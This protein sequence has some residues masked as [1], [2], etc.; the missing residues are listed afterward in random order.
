[1]FK[2]VILTLII[3]LPLMA[4]AFGTMMVLEF[5][6]H[7]SSGAAPLPPLAF[8]QQKI[9]HLM[10]AYEARAAVSK[11]E[12]PLEAAHPKPIEAAPPETAL[13]AGI[14]SQ[15]AQTEQQT[16]SARADVNAAPPINAAQ[17]ASELQA[18]EDL[19]KT[20]RERLSGLFASNKEPEIEKPKRMICKMQRG[21]KRCQFPKEK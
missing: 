10:Q 15:K 7:Q 19:E 9:G 8:V 11:G 2:K 3:P 6:K 21:F 16:K 14:P 13:N 17:A 12:A 5:Q 1:M 4:L 18:A 20:F